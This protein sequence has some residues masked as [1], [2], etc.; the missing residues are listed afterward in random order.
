MLAAM[1]VL[2]MWIYVR[3][4]GE[5]RDWGVSIDDMAELLWDGVSTPSHS[6]IGSAA[7]L[8]SNYW[9]LK[10]F[11]IF[12]LNFRAMKFSSIFRHLPELFPCP[13]KN[14]SCEITY[15]KLSHTILIKIVAKMFEKCFEIVKRFN[16]LVEI[17]AKLS[18]EI[19]TYYRCAK[20]MMWWVVL[21]LISVVLGLSHKLLR[22]WFFYLFPF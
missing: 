13:P 16:L 20:Q 12:C 5:H 2:C 21:C 22:Q 10:F 14:I 9:T 17:F 18:C 1:C 4:T 15:T 19:L 3:Y 8:N 6:M 11:Q 7:V